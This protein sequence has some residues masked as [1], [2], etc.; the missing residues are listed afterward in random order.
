MNKK[1]IGLAFITAAIFAPAALAQEEE[2]EVEI[3]PQRGFSI[4]GELKTGLRVFNDKISLYSAELDDGTGLQADLNAGFRSGLWGFNMGVRGSVSNGWRYVVYNRYEP[5][6]ISDIALREGFAYVKLFYEMIDIKAGLIDSYVW[7]T[8]GLDDV[9]LSCGYGLRVEVTM[10]E[11]VNFGVMFGGTNALLTGTD[12]NYMKLGD[13]FKQSA[14]GFSYTNDLFYAAA[15]YKIT[16]DA[17]ASVYHTNGR[18]HISVK[19]VENAFVFGLGITGIENCGLTAEVIFLDGFES[20]ETAK[21]NLDAVYTSMEVIHAGFEVSVENFDDFYASVTPKAEI[22]I[23]ENISA[24]LFIPLDVNNVAG[25]F[26]L[27]VKP[28]ITYKFGENSKFVV[29]DKIDLIYP[30]DDKV[31]NTVQIDFVYSF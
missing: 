28:R 1:I 2:I 21:I 12:G 8:G 18:Q 4:T 7:N 9:D 27:A 17:E 11:G 26:G 30:Y 14:I 31:H 15:A 20:T 19:T 6:V 23:A 10:F 16:K 25:K 5:E 3:E 22:D 24:G 13:F 29:F